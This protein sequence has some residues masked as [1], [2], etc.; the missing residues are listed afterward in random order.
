M[1]DPNLNLIWHHITILK[2]TSQTGG[3]T[4]GG[5]TGFTEDTGL[6]VHVATLGLNPA[7][8]E[9]WM[10]LL[11]GLA[12][13][14]ARSCCEIC[15]AFRDSSPEEGAGV[16]AGE[17]HGDVEVITGYGNQVVALLIAHE[18]CSTRVAAHLL[19]DL[20][21]QH[22]VAIILL[23]LV[24]SVARFHRRPFSRLLNDPHQWLEQCF[25]TAVLHLLA[26]VFVL[27]DRV[28]RRDDVFVVSVERHFWLMWS[29]CCF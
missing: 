26:V 8:L 29:V 20:P 14:V 10:L 25:D 24:A 6:R 18:E 17:M 19:V 28:V 9:D 12:L 16:S 4:K 21:F 15:F 23:G 7:V 11:G 27:V 22:F 2:L 3:E 5:R 13:C 1:D